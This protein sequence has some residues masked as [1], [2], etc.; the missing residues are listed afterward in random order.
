[1]LD[2]WTR[3]LDHAIEARKKEWIRI[4]ETEGL[5]SQCCARRIAVL[6]IETTKKASIS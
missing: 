6:M 4:Q 5:G 2:N 3:V 1:M